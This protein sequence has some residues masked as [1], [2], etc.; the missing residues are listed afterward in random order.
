MNKLESK[1]WYNHP[2]TTSITA[3]ILSQ[4]LIPTFMSARSNFGFVMAFKSMWIWLVSPISIPLIAVTI[5][6]FLLILYV[7]RILPLHR[8]YSKDMFCAWFGNGNST[9]FSGMANGVCR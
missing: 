2:W 7:Y 6:S 3:V 1:E 9:A 4:L 5:L 8:L